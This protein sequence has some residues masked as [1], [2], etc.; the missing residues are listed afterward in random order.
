MN[1]TV[2]EHMRISLTIWAAAMLLAVVVCVATFC[3]LVFD[4]YTGKYS[5]AMVSAT[6][7][8]IYD[9]AKQRSVTCPQCYSS[10]TASINLI[11]TVEL[12]LTGQA[13]KVVYDFKTADDG[14]NLMTLMTGPTSIKNVRMSITQSTDSPG[15]INIVLEEVHR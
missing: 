2:S 13:A 6:S 11:D 9:L 3:L 10:I 4:N 14:D 8:S 1:D 5:D 15:M 7:S 12:R